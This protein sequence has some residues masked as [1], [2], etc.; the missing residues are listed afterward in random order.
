MGTRK[1]TQEDLDSIRQLAAQWG[2]IVVRRAFGDEGAGLDV[3]LDQMEQIAVA[4]AKG[5]TAGALEVATEQQGQ[6]L[7]EQ[8]ACPAC[9]RMCSVGSEERTVH[10]RGGTFQ[11]REA[12]CHCPTCRRDFFPSASTVETRRPR[13]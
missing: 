1:L 2:K 4:A 11:H 10:V 9:G 6:R 8:Q 12:K 5:L 7:G 13:L 3:D